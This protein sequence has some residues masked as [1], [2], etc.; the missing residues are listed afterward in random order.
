MKCVYYRI[1]INAHSPPQ[2]VDA[3][4]R[5]EDQWAIEQ[6]HNRRH[7]ESAVLENNITSKN[8]N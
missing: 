6:K 1:G 4:G 2:K 5:E 7:Y 8:E 3:Y